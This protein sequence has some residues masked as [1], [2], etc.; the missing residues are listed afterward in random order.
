MPSVIP[1][2]CVVLH[3]GH[4]PKELLEG[5]KDEPMAGVSM[6][7][8]RGACVDGEGHASTR[9]RAEGGRG[10]TV[11]GGLERWDVLQLSTKATA[12]ESPPGPPFHCRSCGS[13]ARTQGRRPRKTK[14]APKQVPLPN[15]TLS[16]LLS[17]SVGPPKDE[18]SQ[19]DRQTPACRPEDW[20][21]TGEGRA[22]IPEVVRVLGREGD[23]WHPTREPGNPGKGGRGRVTRSM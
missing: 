17:I 10:S 6:S 19:A 15:F 22:H 16:C 13:S 7:G 4:T 8:W 2:S 20:E 18:Q 12:G 3:T 9:M 14:D 11:N 5:Q 21:A 1:P 23:H